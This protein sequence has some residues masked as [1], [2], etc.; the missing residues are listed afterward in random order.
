M[1]W[2]DVASGDLMK[3][4]ARGLRAG[5]LE[6]YNYGSVRQREK[7]AGPRVPGLGFPVQGIH[8]NGPFKY[9]VHSTSKAA[10]I[11]INKAHR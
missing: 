10:A 7:V 5:S 4:P 6:P 1:P 8:P 2:D 3:Q 11:F 9:I